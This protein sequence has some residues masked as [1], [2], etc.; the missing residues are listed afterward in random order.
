MVGREPFE[1]T[2]GHGLEFRAQQ[3]RLL[4]EALMLAHAAADTGERTLLKD[5]FERAGE[6][7]LDQAV[8]ETA[9]V[10]VK[11]AGS[12]A[13]GVDTMEAAKGLFKCL[14]GGEAEINLAGSAYALFGREQVFALAW[15]FWRSLWFIYTRPCVI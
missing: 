10:D 9:D 7:R 4:A 3:A 13:F 6:I 12:D 15:R 8:Y 5:A 1:R 14:V 11:R 2:D